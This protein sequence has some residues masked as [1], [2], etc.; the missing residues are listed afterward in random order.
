MTFKNQF[1]WGLIIGVLLTICGAIIQHCLYIQFDQKKY[2]N[3]KAT[4]ICQLMGSRYY[5]SHNI[6][7]SSRSSVFEDRWNDYILNGVYP[8]NSNHFI[9]ENF[10][11]Q[12]YTELIEDYTDLD[13]KFNDLH[14]ILIAIRKKQGSKSNEMKI[15]LSNK[16]KAAAT[17]LKDLNVKMTT[18]INTVSK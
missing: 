8:W 15:E 12:Y 3:T 7:T 9:I 17:L 16:E 11:K 18:I 2:T 10:I 13:A 6:I 5:R 4:E 14:N 1:F